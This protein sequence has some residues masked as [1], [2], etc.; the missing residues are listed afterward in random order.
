M[1]RVI[2]GSLAIALAAGCRSM[3]ATPVLLQGSP[4]AIARLA[5]TWVGE[6]W[7]G[8]AG[9][10]GS[11][12]FSLRA[13]SDSLFGDV[14]MVDPHGQQLRPA[15]PMGVH[16]THVQSSQYLRIDIVMAQGDSV[17]GVLEPYISPDCECTVS[18]TFFGAVKGDQI[19]GRFETRNR[20]EVRAAG[21]W[22]LK[23]VGDAMR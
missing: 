16:R 15:D 2:V 21:S 11:L 19:A 13:G 14:T 20:G 1:R 6:Y 3:P 9:R 4:V 22:E 8:A 23:R 7:G 18:T 12:S 17:R 5:G 10:G